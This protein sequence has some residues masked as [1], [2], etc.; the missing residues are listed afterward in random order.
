MKSLQGKRVLFFFDLD[1]TFIESGLETAGNS[2]TI[3]QWAEENKEK[4]GA[5]K[6]NLKRLQENN[7][8]VGLATGRGLEFCKRLINIILPE[9]EGIKLGKSVVEGGLFIYNQETDTY[10]LSPSVDEKSAET[11]GEY[12][13]LI[14]SKM[15]EMGMS[16]EG[17][18]MMQI[19]ANPPVVDGKRDTDLYDRLLKEGL[20]KEVVGKVLITH[21][22]SAVD[23]TPVG[24]D[25]MT[26]LRDIV[27]EGIAVYFGDGKNDETAMSDPG[28]AVVS[29]P[30]NA[31]PDIKDYA[32]NNI[33]TERQ[34]EK[35]GLVAINGKDLS[36][37]VDSLRLI[38]AAFKVYKNKI[39]AKIA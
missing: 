5:L 10:K 2:K 17:G 11:L 29:T 28:V 20:P 32:K 12:H 19:S 3:E 1:G 8:N 35:I 31:H 21:S 30:E 7:I 26:A 14:L 36:G 16:I 24:V 39:N 9:D 22:S 18:K 13:D 34:H 37:V 38:N 33:G 4:I 6:I 27:A 25:K 23:V 15:K